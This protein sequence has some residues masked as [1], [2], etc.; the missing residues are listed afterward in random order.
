MAGAGTTY[1]TQKRNQYQQIVE[2]AQ[3]AAA[4]VAAANAALELLAKSQPTQADMEA[5]VP[6]VSQAQ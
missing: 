1:F 6:L 2:Q 5:I 3:P 4:K